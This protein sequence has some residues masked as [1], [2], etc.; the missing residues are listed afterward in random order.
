MYRKE[1]KLLANYLFMVS[2]S[3]ECKP[4]GFRRTLQIFAK[5]S[6]KENNTP[7]NSS[8]PMYDGVVNFSGISPEDL[9]LEELVA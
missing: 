4:L 3:V 5:D 9:C 8:N 1:Y 7:E 6:F 2:Y